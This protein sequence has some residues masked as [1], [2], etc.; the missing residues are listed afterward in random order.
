LVQ[1]S[2][3]DVGKSHGGMTRTLSH[4]ESCLRPHAACPEVRIRATFNR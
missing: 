3:A 4:Q 2:A 1:A